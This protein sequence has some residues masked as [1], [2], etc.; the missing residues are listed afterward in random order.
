[1]PLSGRWFRLAVAAAMIAV[2][3]APVAAQ[4]EAALPPNLEEAIRHD[5]GPYSDLSSRIRLTAPSWL[6]GAPGENVVDSSTGRCFRYV[7]GV[8]VE[9][10]K[11]QA[12]PM[13][14]V[15]TLGDDD[16]DRDGIPTALDILIGAKKA[17]LL[18]SPYIETYRVLGYP[19]G[20]MPREEGVCT[21]VVVRALRNAGYDLQSLLSKDRSSVPRAYPAITKPDRNIDHRRVRNLLVYF[22]RHFERLPETS[23]LF[24]GDIVFFDTMRDAQPEHI[25]VVSDRV[26]A[27]GQPLIINSWTTGYVT[28][29]MDLL[30]SVRA[31]HRFRVKTPSPISR[32]HLTNNLAR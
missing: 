23:L 1:V 30:P 6:A 12:V 9:L 11:S 32:A 4:P 7:Q 8:A 17:V 3:S 31:T 2:P 27:S 25:G 19:N 14:R 26:G 13:L 5:K 10:C 28:S 16:L 15:S 21:D 20:D 22:K 24:P 29:E 18:A